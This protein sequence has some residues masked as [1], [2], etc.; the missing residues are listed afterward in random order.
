MLSHPSSFTV[1]LNKSPSNLQGGR[2]TEDIQNQHHVT[3]TE[4]S[5][6]TQKRDQRTLE[7]EE[8]EELYEPSS[9]K[10]CLVYR[11]C[12]AQGPSMEEKILNTSVDSVEELYLISISYHERWEKEDE[13]DPLWKQTLLECARVMRSHGFQNN[14]LYYPQLK[15]LS[16]KQL[17]RLV[18]I[19]FTVDPIESMIE[20]EIPQNKTKFH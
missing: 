16:E 4:I 11:D 9:K 2:S 8:E 6:H 20:W 3:M 1:L 5:P 17:N 13:Q 14:K 15:Y 19:G 12:E 7:E 10:R 18:T